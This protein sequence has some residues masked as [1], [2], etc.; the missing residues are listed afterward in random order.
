MALTQERQN[1]WLRSNNDFEEV[2]Q[3]AEKLH[4]LD[5]DLAESILE[6]PDTF[7]RQKL[8]YKNIKAL[9]LHKPK[10]APTTAQ[11]NIDNNRKSVYYQ[12]S[13]QAAP[14]YQQSGSD[15]SPDGQKRAYDKMQELKNK[16][17]LG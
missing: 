11:Q 12:P 14:P 15:F 6:M 2:M 7:E 4:Q 3:H 16:L 17:R 10:I 5:P 9:G 13:G 8:V 1:N